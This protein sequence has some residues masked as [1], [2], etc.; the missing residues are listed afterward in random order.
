MSNE[1]AEF[2]AQLRNAGLYKPPGIAESLDW[3]RALVLM[4]EERVSVGAAEKTLGALLKYREDHQRIHAAG[5][6][7]VVAAAVAGAAP[8]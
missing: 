3:A 5:L 8:T 7:D 6:S 2:A 1:V 4:G